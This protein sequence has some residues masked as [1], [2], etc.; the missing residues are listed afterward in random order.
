M[1]RRL[2]RGCRVFTSDLRVRIT[3]TGLSTYPVQLAS[4]GDNLAVDEPLPRR[5]SKTADVNYEILNRWLVQ[6]KNAGG[7]AGLRHYRPVIDGVN[8]ARTSGEV[9]QRSHGHGD[10]TVAE[11]LKGAS[12]RWSE[13]RS[14]ETWAPPTTEEMEGRNRARMAGPPRGIC[15]RQTVRRVADFSARK[16][17]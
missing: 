17:I 6:M 11:I 10:C 13:T 5:P 15:V 2:P 12:E 16:K 4:I 3:A 14:R 7:P 9:G 1:N 8:V